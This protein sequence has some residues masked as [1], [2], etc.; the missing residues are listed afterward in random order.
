VTTQTIT[1]EQDAAINAAINAAIAASLAAVN[2]YVEAERRMHAALHLPHSNPERRESIA[3][4]IAARDAES[5]AAQAL[6]T[7]EHDAGIY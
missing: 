3:A 2:A 5:V 4:W 1:A 6:V 7:A